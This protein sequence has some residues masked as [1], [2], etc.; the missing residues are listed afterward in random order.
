MDKQDENKK[1][2]AIEIGMYPGVLLGVRTYKQEDRSIH[3]LYL[4]FIDIAFYMY[5]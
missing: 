3:V 4:P 5:K 1:A 2:W